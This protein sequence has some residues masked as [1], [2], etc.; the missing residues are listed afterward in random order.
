MTLSTL[1]TDRLVLRPLRSQD[2]PAI[3]S[4]INNFEISKWLSVVPYPYTLADAE[5]YINENL[6][7]RDNSRLAWRDDQLIGSFGIGGA[8]GYWLIPDAWG[9]GYAT[10]AA[11]AVVDD[12]FATTSDD[13][14]NSSHFDD[15]IASRKVLTKLGFVDTG[16]HEHMCKSRGCTVPGRS[17]ELTRARWEQVNNPTA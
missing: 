1:R 15:N 10:E 16:P 5:W 14:I 17:M 7:G 9:Q 11:S 2:S 12:H 13:I 6:A 8:L 3:A 4:A